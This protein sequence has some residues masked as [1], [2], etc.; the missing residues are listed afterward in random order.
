MGADRV[1]ATTTDYRTEKHPQDFRYDRAAL[2]Q[3][4][5]PLSERLQ[6]RNIY[7]VSRTNFAM[8]LPTKSV[9][10]S[11]QCVVPQRPGRVGVVLR[12]PHVPRGLQPSGV[13]TRAQRIRKNMASHASTRYPQSILCNSGRASLCLNLNVSEHPEKA[14]TGYRISAPISI[15][16]YVALFMQGYIAHQNRREEAYIFLSSNPSRQ[17]L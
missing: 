1:S 4:P 2:C 16:N 8:L 7:P 17:N 10:D 12:P 5:L 3:I 13:F 14:I 6:C 15:N 11:R 9:S